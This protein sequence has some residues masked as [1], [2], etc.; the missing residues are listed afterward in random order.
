MSGWSW[1]QRLRLSRNIALTRASLPAEAA[2]S[3]GVITTFGMSHNGDSGGNG[4]CASCHGA[5]AQGMTVFPR[6]AGQRRGYLERQLE[7]F[8]TELRA[9]EI[10]HENSKKLTARQ[11]SDVAAFL[12]AQ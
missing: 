6:L 11:I 12:S 4:S 3:C 5:H 1:V 7:A 2:E 10:M 9:N 8:S